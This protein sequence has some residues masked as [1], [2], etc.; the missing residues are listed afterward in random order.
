MDFINAFVDSQPMGSRSGCQ[1]FG[2][3]PAGLQAGIIVVCLRSRLLQLFHLLFVIPILDP[4]REG[5]GKYSW[6]L[7]AE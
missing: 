1:P 6:L 7:V 3:P 4:E 2:G 5:V